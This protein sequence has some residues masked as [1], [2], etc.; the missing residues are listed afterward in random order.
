MKTMTWLYKR[1]A[2]VLKGWKD[3]SLSLGQA[4]AELC[5][6][7]YTIDAANNLLAKT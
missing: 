5:R 1:I 6:L 7:G 3:N 2:T 4:H